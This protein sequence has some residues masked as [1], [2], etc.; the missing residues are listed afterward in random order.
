MYGAEDDPR[1]RVVSRVSLLTGSRT[2]ATIQPIMRTASLGMIVGAAL[3]A[4]VTTPRPM[5]QGAP[6]PVPQPANIPS[7]APQD[8]SGIARRLDVVETASSFLGKRHVT[9]DRRTYPDDCTGLVRA[10]F[11]Q[12]GMSLMS[13]AAPHD[14]GV[15]A[16]FR[17]VMHHGKVFQ[18]GRPM[19][20]DLVFFRDTYARKDSTGL[21]LTHIGLVESVRDD[22]TVLIIHRV[23]EGV[24]R[25][26]A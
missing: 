21:G 5:A 10:A 11:Q 19:P 16:I 20:G 26:R 1:W 12:T 2:L 13:E 24:V 22:G 6:Q 14:N 3:S 18:N 4:C 15:T 8:Y 9:L 17:F 23:H 7:P 25:Y